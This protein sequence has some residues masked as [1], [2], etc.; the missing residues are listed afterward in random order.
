MLS[1]LMMP[2]ATAVRFTDGTTL[3]A[4]TRCSLRIVHWP[5][6][7]RRRMHQVFSARIARPARSV[8]ECATPSERPE[9]IAGASALTKLSVQSVG[10]PMEDGAHALREE[11]RKRGK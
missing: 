5:R 8:P 7:W 11:W 4:R 9:T 2:P 3:A 6:E 1:A 10:T